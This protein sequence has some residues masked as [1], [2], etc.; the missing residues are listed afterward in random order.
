MTFSY[1]DADL[2]TDLN[3]VRRLINDVNSSSPFFTDEEIGFYIESDSN[4]FGAAS[5]ACRALATRFATGVSKSVGKLS[6]S[7]GEKFE[8]YDA[9]SEKYASI[10]TSKGAPQVFAGALTKTQKETQIANTDRQAPVFFL[11]MFDFVGRVGTSDVG[12]G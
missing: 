7:L 6:I 9:L 12:N 8:H 5:I 11:E 1:N 10:A 3:K 2:S 4:V